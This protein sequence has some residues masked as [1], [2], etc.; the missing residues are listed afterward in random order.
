MKLP[1]VF[2]VSA[3]FL[4]SFLFISGCN[5]QTAQGVEE[6]PGWMTDSKAALAKA[7][8]EK[9]AV[10]YDFTGSDWCP[11]CQMLKNEVFASPVFKEFAAKNLVLVTVDFPKRKPIT[12]E[13]LAQNEAL[14]EKFGVGGQ[15]PTVV[16]TDAEGRLLGGIRGYPQVTVMGYVSA[17]QRILSEKPALKK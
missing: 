13:Q 6:L 15:F 3:F 2:R 14:D 7:Q 17:L 10:L 8:K 1:N 16:L 9:K 4:I 5:Q 11:P 12:A